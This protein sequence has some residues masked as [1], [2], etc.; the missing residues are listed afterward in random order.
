ML[1][2]LTIF[3]RP[4]PP[5]G[6]RGTTSVVAIP[7]PSF[8]SGQ[9]PFARIYGLQKSELTIIRRS[10]PPSRGRSLVWSP[11]EPGW[12]RGKK[13]ADSRFGLVELGNITEFIISCCD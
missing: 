9:N 2:S 3:L 11:E 8:S 6:S 12:Q 7:T 1:M 4:V 5:E 10:A 13:P